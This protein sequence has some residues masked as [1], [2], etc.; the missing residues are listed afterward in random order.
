MHPATK[1]MAGTFVPTARHG[2]AA[3]SIQNKYSSDIN[4]A[5]I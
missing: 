2:R 5:T 1:I 4:V 3:V